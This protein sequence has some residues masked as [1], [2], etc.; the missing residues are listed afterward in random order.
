M[1]ATDIE[2]LSIDDESFAIQVEPLG[3]R[4]S[5]I[6]HRG[7]GRELLLSTAWCNPPADEGTRWM[8]RFANGWNV[9]IPH[10]GETYEVE[11]ITHAYHGEAARRVWKVHRRVGGIH[12]EIELTSVPLHLLRSVRLLAGTVTVEQQVV[13][14]SH[15]PVRFGWVEHPVLDGTLLSEAKAVVLG[16]A[17]VPLVQNAGTDFGSTASPWGLCEVDVPAL[18]A[19]LRL[20]WDPAVFPNV[21][22]WQERRGTVGSP[23]F[24]EVD[25]VG[26]EPASHPSGRPPVGLGPLVLEPGAMLRGRVALSIIR[27][28]AEPA[29]RPQSIGHGRRA[30]S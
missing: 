21:H 22:V 14:R 18:R 6:R 7:T 15:K 13:N 8:R 12:A 1:N 11:G 10:A 25:G 9:L 5:S 4:I 27:N 29:G 28:T 30:P 3:A 17:E 26:I 24:G 23:W 2:P 20:E 19:T 16:D